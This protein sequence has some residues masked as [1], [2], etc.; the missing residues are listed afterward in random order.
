MTEFL[1]ELISYVVDVLFRAFV[2]D[3]E[4]IYRENVEYKFDSVKYDKEMDVRSHV[5]TDILRMYIYE[6]DVN[7]PIND[8]GDTLLHVLARA[9][10]FIWYNVVK[11]FHNGDD[12][13]KNKKGETP[14]MIRNDCAL[15]QTKSTNH[16]VNYL[17]PSCHYDDPIFLR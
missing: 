4:R 17:P 9:K 13:I 2:R 11:K 5:A 7:T 1:N 14:E 3:D 10:L 12:K 16:S 15:Q 8:D 6:H